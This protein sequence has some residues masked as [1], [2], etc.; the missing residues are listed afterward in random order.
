MKPPAGIFP[1]C[2]WKQACNCSVARLKILFIEDEAP[3]LSPVRSDWLSPLDGFTETGIYT[4]ASMSRCPTVSSGL[5]RS[6]PAAAFFLL[7]SSQREWDGDRT[8]KWSS[9]VNHCSLSGSSRSPWSP[10]APSCSLSSSPT[11]RSNTTSSLKRETGR[12]LIPF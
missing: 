1:C 2:N 10:P 7:W 4:H 11:R 3:R 8:F 12:E 6:S 5:G 9:V